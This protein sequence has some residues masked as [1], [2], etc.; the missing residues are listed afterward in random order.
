MIKEAK[1]RREALFTGTMPL[2]YTKITP[3]V[4]KK[5]PLVILEV[6]F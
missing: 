2:K 4:V 5:P 6:L 3:K 1:A